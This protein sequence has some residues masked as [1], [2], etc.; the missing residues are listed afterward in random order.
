[1]ILIILLIQIPG[2]SE[3]FIRCHMKSVEELHSILSNIN[4]F[5]KAALPRLAAFFNEEENI[6]M[7]DS[8]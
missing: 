3:L 8:K 5:H 6:N 4:I 2:L 7:R 1:M